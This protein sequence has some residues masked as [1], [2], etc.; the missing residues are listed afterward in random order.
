M[1]S[2]LATGQED[3]FRYELFDYFSMAT[4]QNSLAEEK[5]ADIPEEASVDG[6]GNPAEFNNNIQNGGHVVSTSSLQ[7]NTFAAV[8]STA[9]V[10][11]IGE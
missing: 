7:Q 9:A 4:V 11:Q 10:P 1:I 3:G 6:R 2:W 5:T 8:V